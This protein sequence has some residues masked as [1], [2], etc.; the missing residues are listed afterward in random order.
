MKSLKDIKNRVKQFNVNPRSEMRSKVL[1]E[2][3]EIQRNQEQRSTSDK[4]TWRTIMKNRR[5]RFAAA[6]VLVLITYLCLQIPKGLVA[7]AYALQDTIEAYSSIRTL[8]VK[9]FRT[10]YGQRWDTES[11]IEFDEYGKPA[12]F[13]HQADRISTGGEIGPV[14]V[15]N[16][17]DGSYTWLPKLNLGFKRSGE[18]VIGSSLVQWEVSD[19]AP[20][21]V[22][23]K[24]QKQARDGEIILD[25]NEPEQKSE[26]IVLVVTYPAGSR[27]A[28]W[29]KVLYIDQTTRLIKKEEK[30]ERRD[31]KYQHERT[32]EFFDYN[33]PIDPERFSL[34]RELPETVF[35]ID[36]S[37]K[38]VGLTQGNMTDEEIAEEVTLQF[39]KAASAGDFNKIGQLYL[40]VPGFLIEKLS[41]GGGG[42]NEFKI[43]SIGPV[44]RYPDPDSNIMV[45]PCKTLGEEGGQYYEADMK[46]HVVPVSGQ[47]GRWMICGTTTHTKPVSD[48]AAQAEYEPT[49][50]E[51]ARGFVAVQGSGPELHPRLKKLEVDLGR[52][53]RDLVPVKIVGLSE[54]DAVSIRVSG[55]GAAFCTPWIEKD[56]QLHVGAQ[57]PLDMNNPSRLWL[58]VDSHKHD[59]GVYELT[60]SLSSGQGTELQ[61]PGTVT[62]HDVGLPQKRTIRMKPFSWFDQLCGFDIHEP[63]TRKR[64]EVFLDD[65]A[66]LRNTVCDW[67]HMY[68]PN[69]VLPYVKIAGTDQTLQAAGR[70]GNIS[71]NNLPDLD[72]SFFDPWIG[73]S[74]KRGMTVLELNVHLAITEQ[75]RAFVKAV[76]GNDADASDDTCW[77]LLM[78]LYSQFRDYA[79]SR[80]MTETWAWIGA[81]LEPDTISA[82]VQTARRYQEIGCRTYIADIDGFARNAT[83]LNQLNAQ[84]DS[85]YMSYWQIQAFIALTSKAWEYEKRLETVGTK[86]A[87]Y[88]NSGAVS[89]WCTPKPFFSE[90]IANQ[91]QDV[92][93]SVNGKPLEYRSGSGWANK[94]RG[95]YMHWSPYLYVCLSDGGN[96]NEV[97]MQVNYT[98]RQPTQ[99]K[100]AVQLDESDQIWYATNGNY[101]KSYE[102]ARATSWHACADGTHGYSWWCYWLDNSKNCIV[103]YDQESESMIHSPTWHGLRDSNEDA[104]YYHILQERLKAEADQEGLAR[105]A[106]LTGKSKDAPVRLTEVKD[107]YGVVYHDIDPINGYRQFNQAKREVLRMLCTDQ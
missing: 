42:G 94:E 28:N 50:E 97:K 37:G 79:L 80:G 99:G 86:W 48:E 13:R 57:T 6:A 70:A 89:T 33:Q 24:L 14:T 40:G 104:A 4:Y 59:P 56:Y 5:I 87:P 8:H 34:E 29:K 15:V 71:I 84:S 32:T 47:P 12:R 68:N 46:I 21:L 3:L 101:T 102:E 45:C 105:L 63:E 11:W 22:F 43:I 9:E 54:L 98:L 36:Q 26:P 95:V 23:E 18:S 51:R 66:A 27:S 17:G 107:P 49:T 88:D 82:C 103:W 100:P 73:G 58:E 106:A 92:V 67:G 83:W 53:E 78:W 62:I 90:D 30:F 85:W 1:D 52:N 69:N 72:F 39:L 61:I 77:T 38:E 7:P 25:V 31:G 91:I 20:K 10:V 75:D 60:V 16:D 81:K 64:L 65:M 2:A 55:P 44:H 93:V 96:P 19:A 35:T 76:L 41:G 74:A